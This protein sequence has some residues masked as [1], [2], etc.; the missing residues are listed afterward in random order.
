ML[1]AQAY[2]TAI[3]RVRYPYH[4]EIGSVRDHSYAGSHRHS[5]GVTRV[6]VGVYVCVCVCR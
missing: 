4:T 1:V 6:D 5:N 2:D 3:E